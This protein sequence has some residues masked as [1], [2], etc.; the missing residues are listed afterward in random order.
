MNHRLVRIIWDLL[1][2]NWAPTL[3]KGNPMF[4][5]YVLCRRRRE[6]LRHGPF[7]AIL[8][9]LGEWLR[10]QGYSRE[11]GSHWFLLLQHFGEWFV[12]K[13]Y[14]RKSLC[15][16]HIQQFLA[17]RRRRPPTPK[18]RADEQDGR[19]SVFPKAMSLLAVHRGESDTNALRRPATVFA[20][21][22]VHLRNRCGL[23]NDTIRRN[24]NAVRDFHRYAF[25]SDKS[26]WRTLKP[27]VVLN[28]FRHQ[29]DLGKTRNK[30]LRGYLWHY[31]RFL[32]LKGYDIE[33]LIEVLPR[34]RKPA[35]SLPSRILSRKQLTQWLAGFDRS[36]AEGR[37]DYAMALCLAD[38]GM[39]VG[40]L[41]VLVLGD[42]DWRKGAIRIPNAKRHRPYWL[43]LPQR[44][45]RAI[46]DYLRKDRPQNKRREVFV[47]HR[48][49][50][51]EP[52]TSIYINHRL[53]NVA[54]AQGLKSPLVGTHAL[55]HTF[56]TRLLSC[57]SSLKEVA[58]IL[59]HEDIRS[60]TIYAQLDQRELSLAVRH[61]PEVKP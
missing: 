55:R 30:N 22:E 33:K 58:D 9:P 47:R 40:D 10:Q 31:L 2:G 34:I 42:I 61:W 37:R 6:R 39:R 59:G 45:G 57:G 25:G 11:T 7:G 12:S 19:R 36:S 43:P 53:R 50:C 41:A 27:C 16:E 49:P 5:F 1:V 14:S 13:G 4:E 54:L 38:L 56:A 44:V 17:E 48:T 20:E 8:E 51:L 18:G 28:F 46:A 3:R 29:I 35:T 52:L 24:L 15:Q 26:R 21:Y 60:T 23:A 32:Q